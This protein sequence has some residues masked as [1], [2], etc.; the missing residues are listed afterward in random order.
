MITVSNTYCSPVTVPK[1]AVPNDSNPAGRTQPSYMSTSGGSYVVPY[2][3]GGFDDRSNFSAHMS[4]ATSSNHYKAG[5]V[6]NNQEITYTGTG[7]SNWNGKPY[8]GVDC[9]GF[10]SRCWALSSKESTSSLRNYAASFTPATFQQGDIMDKVTPQQSHVRMYI[11]GATT[12]SLTG[13]Y[14]YEESAGNPYG[15]QINTYT[16]SSQVSQGY[17]HYRYVNASANASCLIV[18][19]CPH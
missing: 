4:L 2:T 7:V 19:S 13:L 11:D 14:R 8:F 3:Y 5:D 17:V 16:L 6:D 15:V 1:L 10:V 9:S 18:T 12:P